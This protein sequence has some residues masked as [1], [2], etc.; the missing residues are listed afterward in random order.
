MKKIMYVMVTLVCVIVIGFLIQTICVEN[1]I[2]IH[3]N[4]SVDYKEKVVTVQYIDHNTELC[5]F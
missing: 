2:K 5:D 4:A 3:L 1:G